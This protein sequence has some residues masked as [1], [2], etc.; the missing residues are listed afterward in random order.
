MGPGAPQQRWLYRVEI[1]VG[2]KANPGLKWINQPTDDS[3]DPYPDVPNGQNQQPRGGSNGIGTGLPRSLASPTFLLDSAH[4]RVDLCDVEAE[5]RDLW[6]VS[7]RAKQLFESL[8][9]DAFEFQEIAWVPNARGAQQERRWLC[10]IVRFVDA[11][12][13]E[14]SQPYVTTDPSGVRFA[15]PQG[16]P[17]FF[18]QSAIGRNHIFRLK[19]DPLFI[20]CDWT[21]RDAF[22]SAKFTNLHFETAGRIED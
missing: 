3:N 5:L 16:F 13:E 15:S 1:G 11:L 10:D 20:A 21:F 19:Y 6:I 7:D 18:S 17:A 14:K 12:V 4:G 8:D 22:Q 2:A 9:A